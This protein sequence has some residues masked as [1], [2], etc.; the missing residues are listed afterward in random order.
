MYSFFKKAQPRKH[1]ETKV[2]SSNNNEVQNEYNITNCTIW[3]DKIDQSQKLCSLKECKHVFHEKC[4]Q[5]YFKQSKIMRKKCPL[6]N[7]KITSM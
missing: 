1:Q 4:I 6:W 2:Y 5:D 7:Q 3:L